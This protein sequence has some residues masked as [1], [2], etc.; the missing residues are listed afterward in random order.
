MTLLLA[1]D[2]TIAASVRE[3]AA[4]AATLAVTVAPFVSTSAASSAYSNFDMMVVLSPTPTA[5]PGLEVMH[6]EDP[7]Q[8]CDKCNRR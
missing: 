3:P 8:S 1:C 6:P 7:V 4:S 2:I 5:T